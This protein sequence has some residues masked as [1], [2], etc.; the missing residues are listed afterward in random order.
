DFQPLSGRLVYNMG[1]A[2]FE[3][4]EAR[5]GKEGI[6][7]FLYTLR[8]GILGGGAEEIFQQEFR[9]KPDEFDDAFDKWLKAH[10]KPF[11]D[12]HR[13][14]DYGRAI[15]PNPEKTP[16]TQVFGFAPSPSGELVAALTANRSEGEAEIVLLSTKDGTVISNLTKSLSGEFES[17][18]INDNFVA[19][20]S[21]AFDPKGDSIAFFGRTG[22]RRSLIVASVLNP[23]VM[24]KVAL[25]LDQATS[26]CLLPNGRQALFTAL[27]DGVS[28]IYIADL[29][30]GQ[31]K[32]LSN[33]SFYDE[34]PQVSP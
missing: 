26:P 14:S 15:T 16:Y 30:S 5:F 25:D 22:K 8:K 4:M 19:G 24:H 7:Q 32:N 18:S 23:H 29:E 2:A 9:M 21:L 31:V 20:H 10:F 12:K 27:K 3:F 1:H 11:R 33:D 6:R 13:P 28:D 34:D 17:L